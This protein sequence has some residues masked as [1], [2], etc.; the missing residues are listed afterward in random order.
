MNLKNEIGRKSNFAINVLFIIISAL[1]VYPILL[2]VGISFTDE[3]S[4][5]KYG[6]SMIPKVFSTY[7]YRYVLNNS[8][9]IMH[10]YLI[11]IITTV[12]GTVVG[13]ASVAMYAYT[14]SR[15]GFKYKKLF[16]FIMFFTMLFSGGMVSWYMICSKVLY[17]QNT[18][19]ALILPML[20]SAWNV[21]I[22]RTFFLTTIPEAII[23]SAKLDGASELK[24]F[25]TI[26]VPLAL[27]G[28]ATIALFNTLSYWNDWWN[29]LMLTTKPELTNLQ[30]YLYKVLNTMNI[31]SSSAMASALA[32]QNGADV[33]MP[34]E[35]ARMAICMLA[36]GPII[37]A[38]PF[39]Q[40]YFVQ[41]LTVGAVKG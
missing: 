5:I 13:T 15:N 30:Y 26:V 33:T 34:K 29:A 8:S 37:L 20:T 9:E 16:T 32:Q 17:I 23:E 19:F 25:R 40:K 22:M 27:P 12:T 21:M 2:I 11:T 7:A 4:I 6:Y 18:I 14:I 1:C 36:I 41:G 10:A 38:Y 39:F 28:I 35:S 3:D 24:T 31:N